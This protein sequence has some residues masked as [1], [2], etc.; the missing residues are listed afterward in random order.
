MNDPG[1]QEDFEVYPYAEAELPDPVPGPPPPSPVVSRSPG[2]VVGGG[3][4]VVSSPAG[5]GRRGLILGVIAAG[6]LGVVGLGVVSRSSGGPDFDGGTWAEESAPAEEAEVAAQ[7][8]LQTTDGDLVVDVPDGWEVLSEYEVLH[9]HHP[10]GAELVARI[11][12]RPVRSSEAQLRVEAEYTRARFTEE[13]VPAGDTDVSRQDDSP[14][15]S[16]T[17]LTTGELAGEAATELVDYQVDTDR[18]RAIVVSALWSQGS[19]DVLEQVGAMAQ[20]LLD[21]FQLL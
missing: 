3:G 2:P 5:V 13:F 4:P 16:F 1:R 9:L 14:L 8:S 20:Q 12:D 6:T 7:A 18:D 21:G 15:E 19:A 11:P 17:M 10:D